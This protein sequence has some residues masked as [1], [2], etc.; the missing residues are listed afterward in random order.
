MSAESEVAE[1]IIGLSDG[2]GELSP[3][4]LALVGFAAPR[5]SGR[6][7]E[8]TCIVSR[9]IGAE[10][11]M[12]GLQV[13]RK[14]MDTKVPRLISILL[15]WAIRTIIALSS[16]SLRPSARDELPELLGDTVLSW[17]GDGD[18]GRELDKRT[19]FPD[20]SIWK[21]LVRGILGDMG[22]VAM[23]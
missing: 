3:L 10:W 8:G 18:P 23:E 1:G 7:S 14:S 21:R 15:A 20:L 9:S 12:G 4:A 2:G 19:T 11:D 5:G 22:S 6:G 16:S 17:G 13:V